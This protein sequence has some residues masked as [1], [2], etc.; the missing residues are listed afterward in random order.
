MVMNK[1]LRRA[2]PV[3]KK[4]AMEPHSLAGIA[5]GQTGESHTTKV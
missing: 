5:V 3:R 2:K 1:I 4:R